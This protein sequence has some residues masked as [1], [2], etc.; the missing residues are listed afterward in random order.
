MDQEGQVARSLSEANIA[1]I[2]AKWVLYEDGGRWYIK[3]FNGEM[4]T[5]NGNATKFYRAEL[6]GDCI[7]R[8]AI[9][10]HTY[11]PGCLR[12]DVQPNDP[13]IHC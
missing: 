4:G 13:N 6:F 1:V 10:A 2:P 3:V 7:Y 5:C 9:Q 11:E 8:G 12:V